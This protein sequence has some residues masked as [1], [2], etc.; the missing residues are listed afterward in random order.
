MS[1]SSFFSTSHF[2]SSSGT[3]SG[4]SSGMVESSTASSEAATDSSASG[5][6]IVLFLSVAILIGCLCR[7][8]VK[9]FDRLPLPFTVL[10]LFVGVIMGALVGYDHKADNEFQASILQFSNLPPHLALYLFLPVLI[11]DSAFNVHFHLFMHSLWASLLLA[12]PGAVL[13][14]M[15]AA[16]VV[17]YCFDYG[18]SWSESLLL[19]SI[20][21]ATDPV[22]VVSLMR[23]LGSNYALSALVEAES[24]LNDGSAYVVYLV[25]QSTLLNGTTD[26]GS[27]VGSLFQYSLGGPA[28]GIL[29]GLITVAVMDTFI[30]SDA[31]IEISLT[32]AVV[33][34]AFY[35][36][37]TVLE[38]SAVLA[39]V[40]LGLVMSKNRYSISPSVQPSLQAVW[41]SLVFIA[42]ILIFLLI[43]LI[44]ADK[45]FF[46]QGVGWQDVGCVVLLYVVLHVVRFLTIVAFL[47]LFR[48]TSMQLSW[49]EVLM[50]SWSGV[51][52]GMS[53]LLAIITYLQPEYDLNFRSRLTFLV[54]G[55]ALLTL[56]INCMS[57][58]YVLKW[59]RLDRSTEESSL[60]LQ[61]A[62]LHMRDETEEVMD[63]L[64]SK[65]RFKRV[66]WEAI[67]SYLPKR[68]IDEV[69]EETGQPPLPH[70]PPP[71]SPH[72]TDEAEMS[73]GRTTPASG[74]V[75]L[76]MPPYPTYMSKAASGRPSPYSTLQSDRKEEKDVMYHGVGGSDNG[77][78]EYVETEEEDDDTSSDDS[79]DSEL[80]DDDEK[81]VP[82]VLQQSPQKSEQQANIAR[83]F[84]HSTLTRITEGT[85]AEANYDRRVETAA[86]V[87]AADVAEARS[88]NRPTSPSLLTTDAS[89][90]RSAPLDPPPGPSAPVAPHPPPFL[91]VPASHMWEPNLPFRLP[92]TRR[93]RRAGRLRSNS[94]HLSIAPLVPQNRM[95]RELSVRYLTAMQADYARQFSSGLITRS[96][97]RVLNAACT[98]G[99]SKASVVSCWEMLQYKMR[100][101][102]WLSYC[103]SSPHLLSEDGWYFHPFVPLVHRL[104]YAHLKQA[105]ELA[106]AFLSA[107]QRLAG[108]M[109]E[110]PEVSLIDTSVLTTV[111][112]QVAQLQQQ[113]MEQW[114]D[115]SDGYGE[116]HAAVV[117]RHAAIML[118]HFQQREIRSLHSTGM[119]EQRE[120]D[121][122]I[123][124][125][126]A[127]L[128]RLDQRG[129][130]MQMSTAVELLQQHPLILSLTETSKRRL[131][132]LVR[133]KETRR[134]HHTHETLWERGHK[135]AGL[136]LT[137]RGTTRVQYEYDEDTQADAVAD[138]SRPYDEPPHEQQQQQPQQA[139]QPPH[140]TQTRSWNSGLS[141]LLGRSPTSASSSSTMLPPSAT[142]HPSLYHVSPA[143]HSLHGDAAVAAP[144][145]RQL[146]DDKGKLSV[147]GA[148][149]MLTGNRTLATCRTVTMAESFL[150]DS[151][152]VD[153][154]MNEDEAMA[155]L[156]R[157]AADDLIKARWTQWSMQR[158]TGLKP[159]QIVELMKRAQV[160]RSTA[161]TESSTQSNGVAGQADEERAEQQVEERRTGGNGEGKA[162]VGARAAPTESESD[163]ESDSGRLHPLVDSG[164]VQSQLPQATSQEP[165]LQPQPAA[166]PAPSSAAASTAFQHRISLRYNDVLLIV[167]GSAVGERVT[168]QVKRNKRQHQLQQLTQT[169]PWQ[170]Q[171]AR[172]TAAAL[173]GR[174]SLTPLPPSTASTMPGGAAESLRALHGSSPLYLGPCLLRHRQGQLLMSANCLYVRWEL[175]DEEIASL[176]PPPPRADMRQYAR[177]LGVKLR[178]PA[179]SAAAVRTLS[180][181]HHLNVTQPNLRYHYTNTPRRG[182]VE[183]KDEQESED[184]TVE[185][186]EVG[187]GGLDYDDFTASSLVS[188]TS[189]HAAR[190]L[191]LEV[192][193]NMMTV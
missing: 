68:L 121:L 127:K 32:I 34:V 93:S 44:I 92:R 100:C 142:S 77:A 119:L 158:E 10:L 47:P 96:A 105:V 49:S 6:E 193:S 41:S 72:A 141:L 147:V 7:W 112:E 95:Q 150:L 75:L 61:S 173:T 153:M 48:R 176:F 18:W 137:V 56:V 134:W 4:S 82:A 53:L 78:H 118:L 177:E 128:V 117:T 11:F 20:L 183:A 17:Y 31:E 91:T 28:F 50:V 46:T 23:D 8:L 64:C 113:A 58:R 107:N 3:R 88:L 43:G 140:L 144:Q 45:L 129:L 79:T 12:F 171:P 30:Y 187:E 25:V 24:L 114:V 139:E 143:N 54:S 27:V 9:R 174:S 26:A 84:S 37:D 161:H 2:S 101:P 39:L 164:K 126:N 172:P 73:D 108:V 152:C 33:Y 104:M 83:T 60:V 131:R 74:S 190:M 40:C 21:A 192:E 90:L 175:R 65:T 135:C 80:E 189:V 87:A 59:L 110:F 51:R 124:L 103:Y 38:V 16:L 57:A 159:Y 120:F 36:A 1:T 63:K 180:P 99:V 148:Y 97:L 181:E 149:E 160:F 76:D 168:K 156:V 62:L 166:S 66:D 14:L 69:L 146:L 169:Q 182:H 138:E 89:M 102:A 42:N 179:E 132:A 94:Q 19:G 67:E 22:A 81:H 106:T 55:V 70:S 165:L 71:N 85:T 188:E 98:H 155:L 191:P 157:A 163:S 123:A 184:E 185:E 122:I 178:K 86:N 186:A 167:H 35:I 109:K 111:Q 116:A 125:I 115:I 136:I 5:E 13:A 15:S 52:G 130:S 29:V 170:A 145:P 154:L 151:E 133:E 162:A